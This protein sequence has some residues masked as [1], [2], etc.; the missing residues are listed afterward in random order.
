M[1]LVRSRLIN[2]RITNTDD[3]LE[4]VNLIRDDCFKANSKTK[5]VKI[6]ILDTGLFHE[7][8][9]FQDERQ[10]RIKARESFFDS[11]QEKDSPKNTKDTHGHGTHIAG[12]VLQVAPNA[13]LYIGR[14]VKGNEMTPDDADRISKVGGL[15]PTAPARF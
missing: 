8:P 12:I 13:D 7:H 15:N 11:T 14:V 6:A 2:Y 9:F 5:R 1:Y 10:P 4:N 3:W